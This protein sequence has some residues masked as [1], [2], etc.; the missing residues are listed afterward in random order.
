MKG[1]ERKGE[2]IKWGEEMKIPEKSKLNTQ[3]TQVLDIPGRNA[4]S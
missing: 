3:N 4:Y 2:K 1:G